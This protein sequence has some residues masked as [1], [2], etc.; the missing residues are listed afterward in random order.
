MCVRECCKLFSVIVIHFLVRVLVN[1]FPVLHGTSLQTDSWRHLV[2]LDLCFGPRFK[3]E[4]FIRKTSIQ[5]IYIG[6]IYVD[7]S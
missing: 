1:S 3:I 4:F 6:I 2:Y 5:Y 7:L